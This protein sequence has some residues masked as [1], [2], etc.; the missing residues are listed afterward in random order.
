MPSLYFSIP[1]LVRRLSAVQ[2]CLA[3][4]FAASL[5]YLSL[6]TLQY[7]GDGLRWY[8]VISGSEAHQFKNTQSLMYP[9]LGRLYF[10]FTHD[11]LG[12]LDSF[13]LAQSMNALLGG[14]AI[15]FFTYVLFHLTHC[16]SL[17]FGGAAI[18]AFSRAFSLHATDMTEP[19]PSICLSLLAMALTV[20]FTT[21]KNRRRRLLL[22]AS[23]SIGIAASL[24]QAG[25]LTVIGICAFLIFCDLAPVRE[26]VAN[27]V[28]CILIAGVVALGIYMSAYLWSGNAASLWQA[29][30]M[31][32]KTEND[33]TLGIYSEFSWR[34]AGAL[35][36]GLG[37][38]LFGLRA[39]GEQGINFFAN[40]DALT[41][42]WTV[43]LVAYSW[44]IVALLLLPYAIGNP[45]SF[46]LRGSVI[47]ACLVWLA[48]QLLLL[49]FWGARYSKLWIMPLATILIL[50]SIALNEA[51]NRTRSRWLQI[52][53]FGGF[54]A[55]VVVFGLF[56]NM[57]PDRITPNQGMQ[58]TLD[59]ARLVSSKDVIVSLWG[60]TPYQ[61]PSNPNSVSLV[62]LALTGELIQD[63]VGQALQHEVVSTLEHGGDVYF[64]SLLDLS[65]SEWTLFNEQRL[66]L[67]YTFL[68]P[69]RQHASPVMFLRLRT[70]SGNPAYLWKLDSTAFR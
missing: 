37:D 38:A 51:M 26:R 68:D 67:P 44:G 7:S 55:P 23:L 63:Q 61:P 70:S 1:G 32:L 43:G 62:K 28:L 54:V 58:D 35:V 11:V 27:A 36:F 6:L 31:S 4:G 64:Y 8:G 49:I 25:V 16:W 15:A 13:Q 22:A 41:I 65:K 39:I 5:L 59:I 34:R 19:M 33:S 29:F 45:K 17:A 40:S 42:V 21:E 12:L 46:S 60:G 52:A 69:Y 9:V 30:Q 50:L 14:A 57:I 10:S 3:I 18:L 24:Y 47:L 20:A 66:K 2:I 53:F 48:P 56:F